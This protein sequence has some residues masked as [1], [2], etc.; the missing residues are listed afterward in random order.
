MRMTEAMRVDRRGRI[1]I[2]EFCKPK[3]NAY[4]LAFMDEL[5]LAIDELN[6]D[7]SV[8]VVRVQ[9]AIPRFFCAG[10]D[11]KVFGENDTPT[12][13][14]LVK[15]A[16]SATHKMASSEKVYVAI[17]DGHTLGGGLEIALAC[18]LRLGSN[19][20]YLLGM[21]EVKLG[22]MPGNGGSQRLTR[23]VGVARSL[24]L[25][26][27]GENIGPLEAYR[28]GLL[29]QIFTADQF[30]HQVDR[31]CSE[32]ASGAPLA[33]ASLKRAIR[34]GAQMNLSEAL[35]LETELADTLYDTEDANEGFSAFSEKRKPAFCG[36]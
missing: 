29:N 10:A 1:G 16:N 15:Q 14:L 13:K 4:D 25:C 7:T 12:N 31:Y 33:I 34:Q 35:A 24:E 36:R 2:I 21:S 17:L 32:L 20:N 18:D 11:I 22:L 26:L 19:D 23:V 27:S 6:A 5:N 9:S 8:T 30:Q 28:I 3:A